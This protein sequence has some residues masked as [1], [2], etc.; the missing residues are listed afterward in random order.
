MSRCMETLGV[1]CGVVLLDVPLRGL[2]S[3]IPMGVPTLGISIG[4][5]CLPSARRGIVGVETGDPS[6]GVP[7]GVLANDP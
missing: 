6:R 3:G 5:P 2:K 4:D 1:L 7:A